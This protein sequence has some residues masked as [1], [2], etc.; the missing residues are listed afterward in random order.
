MAEYTKVA[1]AEGE[2][3]HE[4]DQ[5]QVETQYD[6]AKVEFE[7]GSW[8]I[9]KDIEAD[10]SETRS[11]GKSTVIYKNIWGGHLRE[12]HFHFTDDFAGKSLNEYIWDKTL[13]GSGS[14]VVSE[15][16][17]GSV[18]LTTGTTTSD[19]CEMNW[20]GLRALNPD[21]EIDFEALVQLQHLTQVQVR[22]GLKDGSTEYAFFE[23]D[24]TTSTDNW[25][26]NT[27]GGAT[28]NS[29][30]T[31]NEGEILYFHNLRIVFVTD[32]VYFYFDDELV[33]DAQS[34]LPTNNMEPFI[35]IATKEN[36]DKL[37]NCDRIDILQLN[38]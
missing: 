31:G 30:D 4:A 14:I 23:Y 19:S 35:Y 8:K 10:T 27:K 16:T 22:V 12:K 28:A 18:S 34:A 29:Q 24:A 25:Y 33:W 11:L 21:R 9:K 36:D 5:D 6:C 20:D 3:L 32:H 15:A 2:I 38:N 26:C 13:V 7:S 37:V 17:G 1:L